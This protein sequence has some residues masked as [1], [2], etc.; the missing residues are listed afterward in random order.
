MSTADD[1]YLQRIRERDERREQR[2]DTEKRLH[3]EY[4]AGSP[5]STR[6]M[7]F[8]NQMLALLGNFIPDACRSEAY[9]ELVLQAFQ[10][11]VEITPVPPDRD[12]KAKSALDL[13]KVELPQMIIPIEKPRS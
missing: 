13:L 7:Q 6:A 1:N 5:R 2:R 9:D 10:M 11:D 3:D 4:L 8:G 12:V